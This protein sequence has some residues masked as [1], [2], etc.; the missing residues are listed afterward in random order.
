MHRRRCRGSP[1]LVTTAP[2]ACVRRH[3]RSASY[4]HAAGELGKW[5]DLLAPLEVDEVYGFFNDDA[6]AGAPANAAAPIGML[7][8][9]WG[10]LCSIYT[11]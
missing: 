11:F 5:A 2:F 10:Q 4:D 6:G 3:G 7:E 8:G 9:L 1:D